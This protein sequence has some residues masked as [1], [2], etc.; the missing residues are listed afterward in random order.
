M[1]E[2]E[3]HTSVRSAINTSALFDNY[4]C[5]FRN[6]YLLRNLIFDFVALLNHYK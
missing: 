3:F 4:L 1:F 6:I 2:A 5:F